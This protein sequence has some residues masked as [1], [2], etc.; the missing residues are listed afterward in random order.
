M[1]ATLEALGKYRIVPALAGLDSPEMVLPL[2]D[3]LASGGLPVLEI[4]LRM[5]GGMEA[6]RLAAAERPNVLVGAGTVLTA[7]QAGQAIEAGARYLVSPGLDPVLV[8]MGL[9]AGL[10][11]L[12]GVVTPTEVQAA[13]GLGLE[14]VKFFPASVMGGPQMLAALRGP[15]PGMKFVPTGGVNMNNLE[16]YL[17]LGNVLA[18]GG[19]WMFGRGKIQPDGFEAIAAAVRETMEF[20][21]AFQS[22][23]A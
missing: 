4:T 22:G 10:A 18:C 9:D 8:R 13:L 14:A 11:V 23:Q 2:C 20:I 6:L 15:F 12:P 1:H 21:A 16:T 19:T 3:A 7:A 5:A 17:R